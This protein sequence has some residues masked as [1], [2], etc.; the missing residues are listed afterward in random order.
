MAPKILVVDDDAALAEMIGIV[1]RNDDYEVSFAA[2]GTSVITKHAG[3]GGAVTV[4]TVVSQLL[5]EV[6]GARYAGPDAT[7]L[8]DRR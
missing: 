5:Y 4:G 2:D 6:T 8:L 1:L 3:T 7:L